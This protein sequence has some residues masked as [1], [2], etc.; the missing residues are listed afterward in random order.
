VRRAAVEK[1]IA[2]KEKCTTHADFLRGSGL[3]AT[4]GT[5]WMRTIHAS[6]SRPVRS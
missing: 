2:T 5:A 4:S 6:T 1:R 3:L